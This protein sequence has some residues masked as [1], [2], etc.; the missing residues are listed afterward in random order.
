MRIYKSSVLVIAK[1]IVYAVAGAFVA[2]LILHWFINEAVAIAIGCLAGLA[3]AY[4][5][6]YQDNITVAVGDETLWVR[7]FGKIL[8]SFI[9]EECSFRANITTTS[10]S[11]GSDSD[12]ILV[13][14]DASGDETSIDCSMMGAGRFYELLEDLGLV[15][16]PNPT[17]LPTT[18]KRR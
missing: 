6:V 15:N 3:I 18:G 12:C 10:D 13:V 16:N 14:S 4:F 9:L 5:A 1:N 8:H 11:A 17:P 7:R 2:A